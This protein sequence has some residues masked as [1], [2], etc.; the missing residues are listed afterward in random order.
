MREKR[1]WR[2]VG[3]GSEEFEESI[4]EGIAVVKDQDGV[5]CASL[6]ILG[7]GS[8]D[9]VEQVGLMV[10]DWQPEDAAEAS[11][12]AGGGGAQVEEVEKIISTIVEL[13]LE[14]SETDAFAHP[15]GTAKQ[16]DAP[17][18]K[19]QVESV[20]ELSL[21]GGIEHLF[22]PHVLGEGDLGESEV[23][24]KVDALLFHDFPPKNW[25]WMWL[26]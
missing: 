20:D 11:E 16:S 17:G 22:A 21:S 9:G 19:P 24:F 2:E 3:K 14:S 23:G 1:S 10:K 8:A 18:F 26:R 12:E 6:F 13:F 5:F 7:Q 15:G 4:G 25:S